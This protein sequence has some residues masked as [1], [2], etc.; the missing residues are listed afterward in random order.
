M[1]F[2]F[3]SADIDLP[4][5]LDLANIKYAVFDACEEI[6]ADMKEKFDLVMLFDVYHDVPEPEK[7][8]DGVC[9]L[10]KSGGQFLMSDVDLHESVTRNKTECSE[11]SHDICC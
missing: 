10:L 5:I 8:T 11:Y 3:V 6:P 1:L 9:Q 2:T 4:T 7:L